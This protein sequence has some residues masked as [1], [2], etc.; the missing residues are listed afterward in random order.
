MSQ[1]HS[2]S[3]IIVILRDLYDNHNQVVMYSTCVDGVAPH[4]HE[5]AWYRSHL[6]HEAPH[7]NQLFK[8]AKAN[9]WNIK[10]EIIS[11]STLSEALTGHDNFFGAVVIML[12]DCELLNDA[13]FQ[14][15]GKEFIGHFIVLVEYAPSTDQF[16]ALNPE[17]SGELLKLS[18]GHLERAR[19]HPG[20]DH[21]A[22]LCFKTP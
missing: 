13:T 8:E 10:R 15:E 21:D 16:Y 9:K 12:V 22:I 6:V 5:I 7:I 18:A 2:I 3:I 4:H 20:T 11:L 1:L 19:S 14:T 17:S